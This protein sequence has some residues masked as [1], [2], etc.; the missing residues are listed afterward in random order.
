MSGYVLIQATF[1]DRLSAEKTASFVIQKGI[2]ACVEID[3]EITSFYRWKGKICKDQEIRISIKTDE[4][5]RARIEETI[6]SLQPY[7]TPVITAFSVLSLNA[8][9]ENWLNNILT[10]QQNSDF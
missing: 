8:E 7:D 3:T 10:P 6:L 1:P 9:A 5:Y 2:A 4:R